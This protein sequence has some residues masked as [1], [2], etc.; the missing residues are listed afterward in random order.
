MIWFTA[1]M[2]VR[3]SNILMKFHANNNNNNT[4]CSS[5]LLKVIFSII[6][7]LICKEATELQRKNDNM[8]PYKF[9]NGRLIV[10]NKCGSS[11]TNKWKTNKTHPENKIPWST[12]LCNSISGLLF[13]TCHSED[14]CQIRKSFLTQQ[15]IFTNDD[16]K[17]IMENLKII[18]Q[19]KTI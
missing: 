16:Y 4:M 3:S 12:K 9:M 14:K 5:K 11:K 19:I 17:E 7:L 1:C 8:K 2:R 15:S 13:E 10:F 18:E 6:T